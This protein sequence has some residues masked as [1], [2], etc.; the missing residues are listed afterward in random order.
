MEDV[1]EEELKKLK[2]EINVDNNDY[3][4]GF[5]KACDNDL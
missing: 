5:M 3:Y 1:C 4:I 2:K